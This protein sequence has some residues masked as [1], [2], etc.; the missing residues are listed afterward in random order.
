MVGG[1]VRL[2]VSSELESARIRSGRLAGSASDGMAGAFLV[3][4]YLAV[5]SS[6]PGG[7]FNH[8]GWE[9][10][11][12]SLPN[13]TPT[14]DEMARVKDLFFDAEETVIQFHPARSHYVNVH[15]FCLHMWRPLDWHVLLPP[16]DL[17][18]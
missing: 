13:R 17:V 14:W 1:A 5:I 16:R 15:P 9:H 10:V 11:S 8:S 18:G 4:G 7:P 2:I 12:V 3:N 6:G